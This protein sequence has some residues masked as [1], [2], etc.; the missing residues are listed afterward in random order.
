MHQ[1]RRQTAI[2]ITVFRLPLIRVRDDHFRFRHFAFHVL[3]TIVSLHC[4]NKQHLNSPVCVCYHPAC[5]ALFDTFVSSARLVAILFHTGTIQFLHFAPHFVSFHF[6]GGIFSA[7]ILPCTFHSFHYRSAVSQPFSSNLHLSTF[8]RPRRAFLHFLFHVHFVSNLVASHFLFVDTR[9][10][11]SLLYAYLAISF[12][13]TCDLPAHSRDRLRISCRNDPRAPLPPRPFFGRIITRYALPSVPHAF[14]YHV[15]HQKAIRFCF[16]YRHSS[17]IAFSPPFP[18][19]ACISLRCIFWASPVAAI[20]LSRLFYDLLSHSYAY[21]AFR[22][23]VGGWWNIAP[24]QDAGGSRSGRSGHK[25]WQF[26]GQP[27]MVCGPEQL[28][29]LVGWNFRC[30][31]LPLRRHR[32][33]IL[34][35]LHLPS[36]LRYRTLCIIVHTSVRPRSFLAFSFRLTVCLRLPTGW[37]QSTPK[38]FAASH[39]THLFTIA[40]QAVTGTP[41]GDPRGVF[42]F[43]TQIVAISFAFLDPLRL[44]AHFHS[45]RQEHFI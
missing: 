29:T 9:A 42:H 10:W 5:F 24:W 21:I 19:C 7:H 32:C 2:V 23:M 15:D 14:S 34:S 18:R 31:T 44:P 38:H 45:R 30:H 6:S 28:W 35:H 20:H 41:R 8:L 33:H 26:F 25:I 43:F 40:V 17:C 3:I 37:Y 36:T 16:R 11:L 4:W 27:W 39:F 12:H 22:V 1:I 13:R